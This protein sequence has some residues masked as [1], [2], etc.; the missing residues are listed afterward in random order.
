M[1]ELSK[2]AYGV[3]YINHI[4]VGGAA[5][6]Q[7][8]KAAFCPFTWQC[9]LQA[10]SLSPARFW[11]SFSQCYIASMVGK[12]SLGCT[13]KFSHCSAIENAPCSL[14]SST[15]CLWHTGGKLL[16]ITRCKLRQA[17]QPEVYHYHATFGC[18]QSS[19]LA[20]HLTDFIQARFT[21][22]SHFHLVPRS[23]WRSLEALLFIQF[24]TV[25]CAD[26]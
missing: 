8:Q 10:A 12:Y 1:G 19:D 22:S 26:S 14:S 7:D 18:Q 4:A 2:W 13:V 23:T 25:C 6:C 9:S 16:A 24:L 11:D 15:K 21:P 17:L 5:R 20:L 3:S